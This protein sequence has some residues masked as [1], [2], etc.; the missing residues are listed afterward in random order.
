M[1]YTVYFRFQFTLRAQSLRSFLSHSYL[2]L[3][4]KGCSI[5]LE[6]KCWKRYAYIIWYCFSSVAIYFQDKFKNDTWYWILGGL[7]F[8]RCEKFTVAECT[9]FLSGSQPEIHSLLA[10]LITSRLHYH[11]LIPFVYFVY[12]FQWS[13]C[14]STYMPKYV[15]MYIHTYMYYVCV[16]VYIHTHTF[17]VCVYTHTRLY[18]RM[19]ISTYIHTYIHTYLH[20]YLHKQAINMSTSN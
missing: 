8:V 11:T 7:H 10:Q 16:C 18:V 4:S 9:G 1:Y 12:I 5:G 20:T 14:H 17:C 19:C 6:G 13:H 2:H 3:L 15:H